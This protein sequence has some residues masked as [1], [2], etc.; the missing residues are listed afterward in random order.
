MRAFSIKRL[1]QVRPSSLAPLA[2]ETPEGRL[3]VFDK[4]I[5]SVLERRRLAYRES[6]KAAPGSFWFFT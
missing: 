2:G 3:L 6:L 5:Q 1:N 4:E